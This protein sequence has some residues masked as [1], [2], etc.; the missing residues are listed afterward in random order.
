MN[1][2]IQFFLKTNIIYT[3]YE[4]Q[5]IYTEIS[6]PFQEIRI[7]S[8]RYII[9]FILYSGETSETTVLM[10]GFGKFELNGIEIHD[11]HSNVF[12]SFASF[13]NRKPYQPTREKNKQEIGRK[14]IQ[15][16]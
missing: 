15:I 12:L 9:V 7:S 13:E 1:V 5:T 11:C 14:Y 10:M 16:Y 2:R 8:Y 4:I 6:P 3:D